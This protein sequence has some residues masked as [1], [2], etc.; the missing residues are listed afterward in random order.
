MSADSLALGLTSIYEEEE[1]GL[2]PGFAQGAEK[3]EFEIDW[4]YKETAK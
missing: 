2:Q 4:S 3:D 1:V